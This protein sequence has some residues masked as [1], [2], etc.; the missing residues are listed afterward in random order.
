MDAIASPRNLER[1]WLLAAFAALV[2]L[3]S[4]WVG[5]RIGFPLEIDGNEAWNAWHAADAFLPDKLY[6]ASDSLINN[7]YPPL[8]FIVLRLIA[9]L[10]ADAIVAGRVLSLLSVFA[11]GGAVYA[12]ARDLGADRP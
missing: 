2:A 5:W 12:C 7:N 8:S 4:A 6:P 9:P 10:F 11:I 1:I 3:F